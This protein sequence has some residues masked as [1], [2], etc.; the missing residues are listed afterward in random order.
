MIMLQ[1]LLAEQF[2]EESASQLTYHGICELNTVIKEGQVAVFFRN[3]HFSSMCKHEGTLYLLVTD[4]GFLE[5]ADTVWE[6][7]D[8]VQGDTVY[9]DQ[10]FNISNQNQGHTHANN[11][12]I[13]TNYF[14]DSE[15]CKNYYLLHHDIMRRWSSS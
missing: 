5:Q 7:L 13:N 15:Y 6:T 3:N 14:L 4:Q 12:T 11:N 10:D 1:A 8:D 9:V 2:L